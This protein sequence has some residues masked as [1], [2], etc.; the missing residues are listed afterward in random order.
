MNGS[1]LLLNNA[2]RYGLV[3]ARAVKAPRRLSRPNIGMTLV[4]SIRIICKQSTSDW[5]Q[6]LYYFIE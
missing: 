5:L 2:E 4:L 3:L 1:E 6:C